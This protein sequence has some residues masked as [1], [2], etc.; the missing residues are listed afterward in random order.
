MCAVYRHARHSPPRMLPCA[1]TYHGTQLVRAVHGRETDPEGIVPAGQLLGV[2][3][4][5]PS[6]SE[7]AVA[8]VR[9]VRGA[10]CAPILNS[11]EKL[12]ATRLSRSGKE[13]DVNP[14]VVLRRRA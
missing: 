7:Q 5:E 12:L 6:V 10:R 4:G 1:E 13:G 2:C 11:P 3:L 8:D 9:R 14:G